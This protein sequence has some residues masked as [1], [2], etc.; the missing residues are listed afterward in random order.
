MPSW[1]SM[2]SHLPASSCMRFRCFQLDI[3]VPS[4]F[5]VSRSF[6]SYERSIFSSDVPCLLCWEIWDLYPYFFCS[7]LAR[8]LC[9]SIAHFYSPSRAPFPLP[10]L[11]HIVNPNQ[12]QWTERDWAELIMGMT[13]RFDHSMSCAVC[14]LSVAMILNFRC[15]SPLTIIELTEFSCFMFF[16]LLLSRWFHRLTA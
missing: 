2:G 14:C 1:L 7:Y 5:P 4:S 9:P 10:L 3:C 12:S 13:E 16:F 11:A 6:V 15:C 8:F